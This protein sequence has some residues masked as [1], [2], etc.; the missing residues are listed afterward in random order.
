MFCRRR[1]LWS[2]DRLWEPL[3]FD[4]LNVPYETAL[5][6]SQIGVWWASTRAPSR[7]SAECLLAFFRP[8]LPLGVFICL[9]VKPSTGFPL[10]SYVKF[11]R[12]V[13]SARS[14]TPPGKS[15]DGTGRLAARLL[16]NTS[17]RIQIFIEFSRVMC[18]CIR[19]APSESD[20]IN[21]TM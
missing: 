19:W 5:C 12:I 21:I 18:K 6:G 1:P 20:Y 16:Y 17:T 8:G 9:H 2:A 11:L 14:R 15:S 3:Q 7:R 10:G 4:V 13:S